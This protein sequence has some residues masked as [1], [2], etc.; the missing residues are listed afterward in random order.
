MATMKIRTQPR[1]R[2]LNLNH[3]IQLD[4]VKNRSV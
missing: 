3:A 1:L 2:N 4:S